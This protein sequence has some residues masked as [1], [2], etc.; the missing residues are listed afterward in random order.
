[1]N[2]LINLVTGEAEETIRGLA[3]T[4]E[5]Y[6][7]ALKLLQERYGDEQYLV[8]SYMNQLL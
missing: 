8:S 4:D 1:M 3:L 6:S 2:Y 5:N 7:V